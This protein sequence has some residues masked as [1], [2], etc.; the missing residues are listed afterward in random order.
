MFVSSETQQNFLDEGKP[1]RRPGMLI[2]T[3]SKRGRKCSLLQP[4]HFN[5]VWMISSISE[6]TLVSLYLV[7]YVICTAKHSSVVLL[8]IYFLMKLEMR[9]ALPLLLLLIS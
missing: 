8:L 9:K 5:S 1:L 4:D 2:S 3:W 7:L 6:Y